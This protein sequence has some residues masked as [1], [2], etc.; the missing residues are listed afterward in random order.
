MKAKSG[1]EN[2]PVKRGFDYIAGLAQ[3]HWHLASQDLK[4]A[5]GNNGVQTI[6]RQ[7]VISVLDAT[8]ATSVNVPDKDFYSCCPKYKATGSDKI[9]LTF[10]SRWPYERGVR[11]DARNPRIRFNAGKT[12][13]LG[14]TENPRLAR[15]ESS[16]V[17]FCIKGYSPK[18]WGFA[19][20]KGVVLWMR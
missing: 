6:V 13:S 16:D 2:R 8:F 10:G 1:C 20:W 4:L 12:E 9:S 5:S 19:R 7:V 14:Y 11:G 18:P 3:A 15:A 17:N